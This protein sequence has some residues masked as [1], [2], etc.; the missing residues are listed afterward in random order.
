MSRRRTRTSDTFPC[1][2]LPRTD[3]QVVIDPDGDLRLRVGA[4][5]CIGSE[6]GHGHRQT[7]VFVCESKTLSRASPVWKA[8]LYG[9]WKESRNQNSSQGEWVVELPDD[10]PGA[11]TTILNIIHSHF[12]KVPPVEGKHAVEVLYELCVLSDKYDLG[13][14]LRPW[15]KTWLQPLRNEYSPGWMLEGGTGFDWT[16]HKKLWVA[17]ELGD[18]FLLES[19]LLEMVLG[20]ET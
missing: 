11:M 4:T 6:D 15:A 9:P 10:H 3:A 7:T 12:E 20:L 1:P 14:V 16:L 5:E 8:M 2:D 19:T 17:W 13:K 18:Q